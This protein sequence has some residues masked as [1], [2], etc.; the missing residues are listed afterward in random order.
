VRWSHLLTSLGSSFFIGAVV[1]AAFHAL[2]FVERFSIVLSVAL[3][4]AAAAVG[5]I[6]TVLQ[7]RALAERYGRMRPRLVS[8]KE[9]LR[10]SDAQTIRQATSD[11]ARVIAEENGD[12]FGAMWF[13]DVELPP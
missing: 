9:K 6:L 10:N 3:P 7:H 13:H 5:V 2:D 8:V 4:T 11:A 1:F 12:W